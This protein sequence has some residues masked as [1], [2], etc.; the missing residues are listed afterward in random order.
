MRQRKHFRV[1]NDVAP[2]TIQGFVQR[3]G[4]RNARDRRILEPNPALRAIEHGQPNP[5]NLVS[6]GHP[7]LTTANVNATSVRL[8]ASLLLA[9]TQHRLEIAKRQ[10]FLLVAAE[11]FG[12]DV[13]PR[14]S[15]RS[16]EFA[17][18]DLWGRS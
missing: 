3:P 14:R 4:T 2:P 15:V 10:L 1:T 12:F 8:D 11:P 7:D 6:L 16:R 18:I 17:A 13:D 9:L 5:L